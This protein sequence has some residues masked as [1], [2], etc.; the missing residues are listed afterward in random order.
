MD[1]TKSED[2]ECEGWRRWLAMAA[3]EFDPP[4]VL[5]ERPSAVPQ[6]RTYAHEGPWT[7]AKS[8]LLRSLGIGWWRVVG[9]P[10]TVACRYIEWVAQR[11]GRWITA[12]V[13][14]CLVMGSSAGP[15]LR[16][17]VLAPIG[18]VLA[19]IFL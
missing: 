18:H 11:P 1:S 8:G 14:W 19:W 4:N 16:I 5:T 2:T 10:V 13:L 7:K 6:L 17:Y 3:D 12:F 15:V 9:L